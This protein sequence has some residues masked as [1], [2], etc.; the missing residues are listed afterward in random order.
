MLTDLMII[1]AGGHAKVVIE[2][3]HANNQDCQIYLVDQDETRVGSVLLGN[4]IVYPLE[5]WDVAGSSCHVA[6][7]SNTT[8]KN[9]GLLA[10]ANKKDLHTVIHPRACVS[11]TA[12]LGVGV[13]VA[14]NAIISAEGRIDDGCIINHGAIVDHDCQIGKYTH[15]APNATLGGGVKVGQECLIGAGAIIMPLIRVGNNV[16]VG[17]GAVVIHDI[18]DNETVV[19]VPARCVNSDE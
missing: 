4:I 13:F 9:L 11:S 18:D 7:G 16:V 14:A 6:I 19:G 17:A 3:V 15:I 1:G 12:T 10:E 5:K 2:A 8:R